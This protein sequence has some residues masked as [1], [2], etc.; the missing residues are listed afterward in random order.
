M[1]LQCLIRSLICGLALISGGCAY[2]YV[3]GDGTQHVIG[4][5][6]LEIRSTDDS[7][8]LAGNVVDVTSVGVAYLAVPN[9]TSVTI[10]YSRTVA[11]TI[12]NHSFVL[13]N[14]LT[15]L[16]AKSADTIRRAEE[17]DE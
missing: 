11:A 5:V 16:N 12:R 9:N 4:L 10:G 7:Q 3:D 17:D 13:G 6:S 14:P 15:A 1:P 8:T 2:S